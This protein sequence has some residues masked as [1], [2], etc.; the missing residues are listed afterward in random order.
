MILC[1]GEQWVC[2]LQPGELIIYYE[3]EESEKSSTRGIVE[4]C[5]DTHR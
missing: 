4:V 2:V 5:R 3:L 1:G